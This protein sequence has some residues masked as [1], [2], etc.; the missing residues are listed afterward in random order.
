MKSTKSFVGTV[1]KW[2]Q[3]RM[4][5]SHGSNSVLDVVACISGGGLLF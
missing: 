4:L 2:N 5:L 3:E 1:T